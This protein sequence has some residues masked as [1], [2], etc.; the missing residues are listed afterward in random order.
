MNESQK[1]III[2][3]HRISLAK[4]QMRDLDVQYMEYM[5]KA[6][7][8]EEVPQDL[9]EAVARRQELSSLIESLRSDLSRYEGEQ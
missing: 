3:R 5:L 2:T 7:R 8:N 6:F 4:Q 1:N 9:Q